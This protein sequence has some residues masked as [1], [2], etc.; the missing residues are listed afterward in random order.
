MD[1]QTTWYIFDQDDWHTVVMVKGDKVLTAYSGGH[2]NG[3]TDAAE[4]VAYHHNDSVFRIE[5]DSDRSVC[6]PPSA[7][8]ALDVRNYALSFT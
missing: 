4:A 2:D 1:E 6:I 3:W 5:V 8:S 7:A